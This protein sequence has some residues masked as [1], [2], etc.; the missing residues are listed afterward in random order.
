MRKEKGDAPEVLLVQ[1]PVYDFALY[2]LHFKPFG[3]MR[4]GNGLKT[5]DTGCGW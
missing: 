3:L 4:M 1:P 5:A 2:D